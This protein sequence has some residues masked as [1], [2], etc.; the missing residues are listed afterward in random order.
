MKNKLD[1]SRVAVVI[2]SHKSNLSPLEIQSV[3]R[4]AAVLGAYD[5]WLAAPQGIDR[6]PWR[7]WAPAI[8]FCEFDA[9]FFSSWRGYNHLCRSKL[10]YDQFAA[11]E[12]ILI[13]QTDCYVFRDELLDWCARGYD[14]IGAPLLND[15]FRTTSKKRWTQW[16]IIRPFLRM[17]LNG[18]LSLR[19]VKTFR[20][21]S[22]WLRWT[23]LFLLSIPEDVFWTNFGRYFYPI[24]MPHWAEALEFS[25]DATPTDCLKKADGHLPFACH[26]WNHKDYLDFWKQFIKVDETNHS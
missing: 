2:P 21:A 12:Y 5:L 24:R 1:A 14:Y 11:Y 26:S 25:F 17:V 6:Q 4:A 22:W 19:R 16:W 8:Q 20:R 15:E 3:K 10:F 9:Y 23:D 13:Y 7:Q 18:G